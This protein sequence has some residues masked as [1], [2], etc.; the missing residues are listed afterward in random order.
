MS[1]SEK[2]K[3]LDAAATTGPWEFSDST[4]RRGHKGEFRA[5]NPTN[6][7]MLVG[8]WINSEDGPSIAALRS[9]LPQIVAVVEA[10]DRYESAWS[11]Y[12]VGLHDQPLRIED[13]LRDLR[14]ALTAL[15]EALS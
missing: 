2:L 8:P 4:D 5:P 6:G 1:A 13:A 10:G 12:G 15:D 3:A 11:G 14:A 9:A 7:L